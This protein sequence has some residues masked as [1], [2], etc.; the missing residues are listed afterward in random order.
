ML[1]LGKLID[2]ES[3]NG[4]CQGLEGRR[5]VGVTFPLKGFFLYGH[6]FKVF[7][8]SVTVLLPS[9]VLVSRP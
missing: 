9:Y 7:M 8:E 6:V 1:T 4:G 3:K 5:G 2:I